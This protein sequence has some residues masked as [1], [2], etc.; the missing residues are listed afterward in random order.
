M[1]GVRQIKKYNKN[2]KFIILAK[3]K[4]LK[5]KIKFMVDRLYENLLKLIGRTKGQIVIV[6]YVI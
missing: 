2:G 3:I 5:N 4:A 1:I 6:H